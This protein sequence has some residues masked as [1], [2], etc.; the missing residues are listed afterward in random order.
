MMGF[1]FSGFGTGFSI[2]Q[3]MFTLVFVLVIG[4]FIVIAVK[5]IS[6]WNK[7]NHSP[8][9]TVPAVVVAKR[10]H[11][12][13]H[14]IKQNQ[15]V[16]RTKHLKSLFSRSSTFHCKAGIFQIELKDFADIRLVIDYKYLFI[17]RY[18]VCNIYLTLKLLRSLKNSVPLHSV[19]SFSV[20]NYVVMMRHP[21][22]SDEVSFCFIQVLKPV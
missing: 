16:L 22:V 17:H 14:H 9:L 6:Q 8:R 18:V 15:S 12:T 7:N 11:T 5:G 20:I 21:R 4:I 13:H 19:I 1:G 10:G 2:F 3:I